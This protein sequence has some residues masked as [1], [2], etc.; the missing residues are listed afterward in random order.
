[1]LNIQKNVHDLLSD[2]QFLPERMK[3]DKLKKLVC[4]VY[5]R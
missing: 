4:Y 2:L 5:D 1:M 3:I